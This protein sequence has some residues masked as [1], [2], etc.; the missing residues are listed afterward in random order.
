MN[1]NINFDWTEKDTLYDKLSCLRNLNA[2]FYMA[3]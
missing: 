1:I 2:M 3:I